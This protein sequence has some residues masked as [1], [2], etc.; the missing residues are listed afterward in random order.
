MRKEEV[1]FSIKKQFAF[2]VGE[3]HEKFVA[4][5]EKKFLP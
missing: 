3:E 1:L 2:N 5:F 4:A